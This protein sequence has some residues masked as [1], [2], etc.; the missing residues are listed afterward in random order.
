MLGVN[1][2]VVMR[3]CTMPRICACVDSELRGMMRRGVIRDGGLWYVSAV[4]VFTKMLSAAT[5]PSSIPYISQ[6][7]YHST[8]L[9]KPLITAGETCHCKADSANALFPGHQVFC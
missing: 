7:L 2:G 6:R 3:A 5:L 9:I 1:C 8:E 4:F